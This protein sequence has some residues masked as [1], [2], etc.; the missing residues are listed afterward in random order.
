VKGKIFLNGRSVGVKEES[1][2]WVGVDEED[3][4]GDDLV[5]TTDSACL[6]NSV[7][8]PIGLIELASV[9]ESTFQKVFEFRIGEGMLES[10]AE[11][12]S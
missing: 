10:S 8:F 3:V 9:Q 12:T 7:D 1:L 4:L 5:E 11:R 2:G 6:P